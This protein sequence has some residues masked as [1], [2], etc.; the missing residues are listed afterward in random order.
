MNTEEK[1]TLIEEKR[2]QIKKLQAEIKELNADDQ[3]L[4]SRINERPI[5]KIIY[6]NK[7]NAYSIGA[8][9]GSSGSPWWCLKRLA[10][11]LNAFPPTWFKDGVQVYPERTIY[12]CTNQ[13]QKDMD[14]KEKE[15]ALE[16]LNEVIPIYNK[17]VKKANPTIENTN[18]NGEKVIVELWG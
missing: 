5:D 3:P 8:T 7:L 18:K 12:Y 1:K 13:K 2:E 17:Y 9:S 15:L 4:L 16:F 11:S 14:A 10:C 6:N